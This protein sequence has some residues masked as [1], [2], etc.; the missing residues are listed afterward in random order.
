VRLVF[1]SW[2]F[3]DEMKKLYWCSF[4]Q[5]QPLYAQSHST[6]ATTRQE[7]TALNEFTNPVGLCEISFELPARF[8]FPNR[9][10]GILIGGESA[11]RLV[12]VLRRGRLRICY[13]VGLFASL[14]PETLESCHA[15]SSGHHKRY[16]AFCTFAVS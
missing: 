1:L 10:L 8:P 9:A 12:Q 3:G 4:T 7:L 6:T 2:D 14:E 11:L 16:P 5:S 15:S 13:T